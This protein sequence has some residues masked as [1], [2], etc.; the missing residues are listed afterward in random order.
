MQKKKELE[1]KT[2]NN[3]KIVKINSVN[4]RRFLD[5]LMGKTLPFVAEDKEPYNW[6]YYYDYERFLNRLKENLQRY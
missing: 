6:A 5:F 4:D 3:I 1:I 2:W